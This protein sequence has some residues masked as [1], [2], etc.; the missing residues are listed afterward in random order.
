MATPA[1]EDS[2][3]GPAEEWAPPPPREVSPEE[4]AAAAATWLLMAADDVSTARAEWVNSGSA[5]L[6]CGTLFS[7]VVLPAWLVHAAAGTA[8]PEKVSGYLTESLEG[9]GVF[10][11]EAVRRYYALTPPS[12]EVD[13]DAEN[14]A[15]L[16]KYAAVLVPSPALYVAGAGSAYWS[17][18]MNGPADLCQAG[19]LAMVADIGR[20]RATE[21]ESRGGAS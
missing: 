5:L 12:V 20:A 15:V 10:Y 16:G 2:R 7:A 3:S 1:S 19:R 8:D 4:R 21:R 18:P 14:T 11:E 17:V 13:W 6:K 9:G